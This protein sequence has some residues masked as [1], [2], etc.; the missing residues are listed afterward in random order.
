MNKTCVPK[1]SVAGIGGECRN[2]ITIPYRKKSSPLDWSQILSKNEKFKSY[3]SIHI[4][5][6]TDKKTNLH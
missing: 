2:A 1:I 5:E 3:Q 4:S 6:H